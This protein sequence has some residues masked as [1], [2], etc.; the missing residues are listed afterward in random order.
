MGVLQ[1]PLGI[2]LTNCMPIINS[3]L[4]NFDYQGQSFP[5]PG[6]ER[7]ITETGIYMI[8]ETSLDYMITE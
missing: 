6:S 2:N 7:M 8:T 3:T 4:N 1:N 5:P